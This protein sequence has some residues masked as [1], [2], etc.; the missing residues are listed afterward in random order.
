[1]LVFGKIGFNHWIYV[2]YNHTPIQYGPVHLYNK[3]RA[4]F[5]LIFFRSLAFQADRYQN[6]F[7]KN[8]HKHTHDEKKSIGDMNDTSIT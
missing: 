3:D 7:Q 8:A 6:K 1:M 4:K 2:L 5:I